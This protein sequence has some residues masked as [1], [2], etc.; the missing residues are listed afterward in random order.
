[1][2][3]RDVD[4]PVGRGRHAVQLAGSLV[5]SGLIAVAVLWATYGF[6]YAARPEGLQINPPFAACVQQLSPAEAQ[7][8]SGVAWWPLLPE[9]YLYGLVIVQ[10]A[11]DAYTSYVLG[12]VYPHGVWFYFPVAFAIKST[13]AFLALLGLSIFAI[14]TRRFTRW[15]EIM[16]LS[17]PPAF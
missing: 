12:R 9:S 3:A 16:F 2:G 6:R 14:A 8:L 10:T 15:R 4:S 7:I 11:A 17:I 13:L 1:R 5:A